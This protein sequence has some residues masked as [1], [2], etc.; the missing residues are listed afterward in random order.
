MGKKFDIV[1]KASGPK[2]GDLITFSRKGGLTR[3]YIANEEIASGDPDYYVIFYN[4]PSGW[5]QR[6]DE[7]STVTYERKMLAIT[8]KGKDLIAYALQPTEMRFDD[9]L[10]AAGFS[11]ESGPGD[12]DY[13]I[14]LRFVDKDNF[15]RFKI[16]PQGK[17]GFDKLQAG[18]WYDI[19]PWT[20]LPPGINNGRGVFNNVEIKCKG[21]RFTIYIDDWLLG[22][23]ADSSLPAG[24]IGLVAGSHSEGKVKVTFG[25]LKIWKI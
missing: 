23:C 10:I 19:I 21:D 14:I 25:Y 4:S 9:A 22:E 5:S 6:D 18:A 13:G 24:N 20:D 16:S 1:S 17:Y 2:T 15:Y 8:V 7:L 11:Y 12:N 3:V